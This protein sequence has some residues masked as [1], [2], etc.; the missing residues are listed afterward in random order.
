MIMRTEDSLDHF[1]VQWENAIIDTVKASKSMPAYL[2]SMDKD[3]SG[4][5]IH[6][7]VQC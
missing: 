4:L 3:D 6:E 5:Y 2:D 1:F 7:C